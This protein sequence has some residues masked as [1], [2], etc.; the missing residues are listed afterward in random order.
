MEIELENM[1]HGPRDRA[2]AAPFSGWTPEMME[3]EVKDLVQDAQGELND[4]EDYIRRGA[5]ISLCA[6]ITMTALT[7]G[8]R[9]ISCSKQTCVRKGAPRRTE[10]AQRR[11]K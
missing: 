1:R 9:S 8:S 4:Y 2:L 3:K 6:G 11:A 10:A 5:N 7:D